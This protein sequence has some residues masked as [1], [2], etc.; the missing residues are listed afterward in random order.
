MAIRQHEL[1]EAFAQMM[2]RGR[3]LDGVMGANES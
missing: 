2:L 3:S 1:P